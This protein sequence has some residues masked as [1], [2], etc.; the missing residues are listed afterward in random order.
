MEAILRCVFKDLKH[1]PP[2]GKAIKNFEPDT[3]LP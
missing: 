3:G 1:K 2:I